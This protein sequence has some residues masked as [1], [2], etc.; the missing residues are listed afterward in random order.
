[1]KKKVTR[2]QEVPKSRWMKAWSNW[3]STLFILLLMFTFRSAV[4]DWSHVP[5]GSMKPTIMEGDRVV[6]NKLAYDLKVPFTMINVWKWGSPERGDVIVFFSPVEGK[7]FVKRVVGV[8]G[9][10]VA[11]VNNQ[12]IINGIPQPVNTEGLTVDLPLKTIITEEQ[13]GKVTHSIMLSPATPTPERT[14]EILVPP[15]SYFVMGDNRDNSFDSRYF[16]CIKESSIIGKAVAVA[17]SFN[18]ACTKLD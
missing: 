14:N 15:G 4:A 10:R 6:I 18:R 16:G 3:R 8:P 9:D 5:T 12:V 17:F 7:R 13:L 1:M 11:V 2:K